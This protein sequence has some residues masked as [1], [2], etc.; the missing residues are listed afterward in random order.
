MRALTHVVALSRSF[1]RAMAP[2]ACDWS[3]LWS[4]MRVLD[5][6]QSATRI[7]A[8]RGLAPRCAVR[9]LADIVVRIPFAPGGLV[10]GHN[11]AMERACG[12]GRLGG[13]SWP[14]AQL[15]PVWAIYQPSC[16][17][18]PRCAVVPIS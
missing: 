3:G 15:S 1:R 11:L 17:E 7:R 18:P 10:D 16:L 9:R 6:G 14:I 5:V 2:T 13:D 8:L 12:K 4:G